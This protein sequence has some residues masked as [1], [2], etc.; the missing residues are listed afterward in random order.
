MNKKIS[1]LE[2]LTGVNFKLKHLDGTDITIFATGHLV[3]EAVEAV[4][5]LANEGHSVELINIHTIKPLDTETIL[6]SVAKTKCV[7]TAEEHQVAG[8]MGESIAQLL[9]KNNPTPIE[10]VAVNDQFGESGKPADLM[11]KY[12]LHFTNIIDAVHKVLNRK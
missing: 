4:K 3:W 12:G 1:L 10:F 7:V 9:A 6:K 11:K 8:G 5:V 2:A